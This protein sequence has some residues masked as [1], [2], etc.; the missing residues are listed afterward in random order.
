MFPLAVKIERGVAL[1]HWR[2]QIY[3][4]RGCCWF[5]RVVFMKGAN[6]FLEMLHC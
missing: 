5:I 1:G 2:G 6:Q 3:R 4:Q